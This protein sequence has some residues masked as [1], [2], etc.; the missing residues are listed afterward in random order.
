MPARYLSDTE[1]ARLSNWP[2]EI[3]DEDTV[4]YFTLSADDL[5]WL[6][7]FNREKNRLCVAVQLATLP[8]LGWSPDDLA[9][10]P[11][12]AL[13]RVA[14]AMAIDPAAASV[15]LTAYGGWQGETRRKHRAQVLGRL[16]W[17]WC[18][19]GERKLLD[20]FL[21]AHALEHDAPGVLLQLACDWM[22]AERIV[23][24]S[25]DTLTRRIASARDAAR[26]E[27]YQRL[28]P[29]LAPPRPVQLDGLLDVDPGLGVTRLAWLRRG[30]TAATPEVLEAELDKLEFLRRHGADRLDLSR[31]PAGRRRMLAESAAA[32]PTRRCNAPTSTVATRCCWPHWPKPTSRCST[33]WCSCSTRLS[34]A[35]TPGLGMNCLNGSSTE[36]KRSG[37]CPVARRDPRRARRP[38]HHRRAGRT[39]RAPAHRDGTAAGGASASGRSRAARS[40]PF[41]PARRPLQVH[42][43]VHPDGACGVAAGRQHGQPDRQGTTP[44]CRGAA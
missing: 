30:A 7:G 37:P 40:R 9:N 6:A 20:E 4:T 21:L 11:V 41:R 39:D 33:S 42:A 24:P 1:L 13:T 31:L 27:A 12:G 14:R 25:V 2:G 32:Q 26:A 35:P 18:G 36:R 5:A 19:S 17:R 29:L 3:A 22:R 38:R 34:P 44:C 16:G 43:D 23:R 8:W 10:C 28:G 15:L